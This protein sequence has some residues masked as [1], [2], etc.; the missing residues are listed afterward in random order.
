MGIDYRCVSC[1]ACEQVCSDAVW[2]PH[3]VLL[4]DESHILRI[5]E[6]IRKVVAGARELRRSS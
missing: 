4:A 5:A 1:P 2:I 3:N 6:A